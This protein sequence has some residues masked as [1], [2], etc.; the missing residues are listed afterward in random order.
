MSGRIEV[1]KARS[2]L[3]RLWLFIFLAGCARADATLDGT[4]LP[5]R[6]THRV[7]THEGATFESAVWTGR[8]VL[9]FSASR[10]VDCT[11]GY[12]YEPGADRWQAMSRAGAPS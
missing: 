7:S 3:F 5:W 11:L 9:L 1:Q 8:E 6:W 10:P 12:R 4:D 2:L